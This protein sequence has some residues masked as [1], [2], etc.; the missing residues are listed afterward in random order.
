[1]N[2]DDAPVTRAD[3]ERALEPY[4]TKAD[5]D[6]TI[7]KALEPYATKADL[8]ALEARM[9]LSLAGE[10]ARSANVVMEHMTSLF[11]V[12]AADRYGTQSRNAR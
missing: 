7:A 4:A 1:V 5:L 6:A 9:T 10:I 12:A 2:D 8:E 11:R 3:L